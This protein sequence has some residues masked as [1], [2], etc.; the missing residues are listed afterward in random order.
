MTQISK[1]TEITMPQLSQILHRKR[2]VSA[3]RAL[4]LEQASLDVLPTAIPMYAWLFNKGTRH[5]AF[6]G[7]PTK[8]L[9][10]RRA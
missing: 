8:P 10:K 4:I 9:T 6:F 3:E 5:P 7:K 2:G 1:L